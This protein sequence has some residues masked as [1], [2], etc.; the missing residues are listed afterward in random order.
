MRRLVAPLAL[1]MA[2]LYL[3]LAIGAAGCLPFDAG[4]SAPAHHHS[5]SHSS[6]SPFCAWV[7]H[8]NPIA[9]VLSVVPAKEVF[10]LVSLLLLLAII[11]NSRLFVPLSPARAPP[12]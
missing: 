4:P 12:Y 8:A 9:A 2:V 6:H 5:P 1:G 11:R 7:C 3:A 10:A